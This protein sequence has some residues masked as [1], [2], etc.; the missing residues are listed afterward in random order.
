MTVTLS[1]EDRKEPAFSDGAVVMLLSGGVPMTVSHTVN[2]E[3]AKHTG[4]AIGIVC[5][6]HTKSGKHQRATLRGWMLEAADWRE[7]KPYTP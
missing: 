1:S 2:F 5:C 3:R 7:A 4:E 6:W